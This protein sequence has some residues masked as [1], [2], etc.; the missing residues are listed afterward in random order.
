MENFEIPDNLGYTEEIRKFEETDPAHADLF[1]AVVQT[2]VNNDAFIK[3]V[4]EEH[5][6]N[7]EN[8][9]KVTKSQVGLE[10]VPNVSTG[11]QTPTFVQASTR[12]NIISG[13]KLST[14]FGKLMKWFVDLKTVA[15]SGKYT[16][17]TDKPTIPAAVRVKGNAESV[18]QTGDVNLTPE[19]IGAVNKNGD[20]IPG[21]LNFSGYGDIRFISPDVTTGDHARGMSFMDK[22]GTDIWGGIG[23][24][25]RAGEPQYIYVGAGTASPWN[26]SEGLCITN[27]NILW[28]GA[29]MVTENSGTAKAATRLSDSFFN[30]GK[31]MLPSDNGAWYRL[32]YL[33]KSSQIYGEFIVTHSW[34]NHAPE[35]SKFIVAGGCWD[36]DC[37]NIK[38]I[39]ASWHNNPN[40]QS[41]PI[42]KARA[43]YYP[44]GTD[45]KNIYIDIFLQNFF[46]YSQRPDTWFYCLNQN[47]VF[48]GSA[49]IDEN[50]GAA[51]IPT[52]YRAKEIS[53]V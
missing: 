42:R 10:N 52:G 8:P 43:V 29:K 33:E 9:H 47:G 38:E 48:A 15:F 51:E 18:Y 31:S 19:N 36:T 28:K 40:V 12:A 37:F 1:N 45:E 44:R 23:V 3:R 46:T 26:S 22:N 17:L 21:R 5:M 41:K 7:A 20:N 11:D 50:F 14:I 34:S 25:G 4:S 13:E 16:D 39:F 32:G 35:L 27:T 6:K 2:L 24:L 53:F 49:W 30:T